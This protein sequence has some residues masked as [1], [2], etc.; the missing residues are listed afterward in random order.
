MVKVPA[1]KKILLV[2]DD[3]LVRETVRLALRHGGF[4][5]RVAEEPLRAPEQARQDQ[6]DLI[7]MDLYMP[8]ADGLELCRRLKKDPK[9]A[10]IPVVLFTG[11]DEAI[12]KLSGKE[13]GA[14]DYI[15]K[16]ID[17][18]KLLDKIKEILDAR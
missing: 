17:A 16:P 7:L 18:R 2:D 12:D 5:V 14:F 4:D 11:S 3:A 8:Q 13:A 9:T 6:P 15:T 1:P 10:Q